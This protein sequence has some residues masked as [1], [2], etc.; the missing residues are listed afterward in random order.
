MPSALIKEITDCIMDTAYPQAPHSLASEILCDAD[1]FHFARTD[2]DRH[3][4]RLRK[5]WELCLD[6]FYTDLEWYE[7]NYELLLKHQYFTDY[8][9]NILQ[10][11]KEVNIEM[12]KCRTF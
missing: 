12:M 7:Q 3:E 5:E 9:K 8:G 4:E 6:R 11:F 1:F 2:Y 10:K